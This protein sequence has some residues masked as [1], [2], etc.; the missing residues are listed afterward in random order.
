MSDSP[1]PGAGSQ[2]NAPFAMARA[3]R[4]QLDAGALRGAYE[5]Y[6]ELAEQAEAR[7]GTAE[8]SDYRENQ[9]DAGLT[10]VDALVEAE[11]LDEAFA[12]LETLAPLDH[13]HLADR[14]FNDCWTR[15]GSY[16]RRRL[17]AFEDVLAALA[18]YERLAALSEA[19]RRVPSARMLRVFAA[20]VMVARLQF[21]RHFD[22]A[23]AVADKLAEFVADNP[24]EH[25]D[26]VSD[27]EV[28]ALVTC[29]ACASMSGTQSGQWAGAAR[30]YRALRQLDLDYPDRDDVK[31]NCVAAGGNLCVHYGRDGLALECGQLLGEL[32]RLWPQWGGIERVQRNYDQMAEKFD[33]LLA[34]N[35]DPTYW[36]QVFKDALVA[37][38]EE[39]DEQMRVDGAMWL[40][41]LLCRAVEASGD[42]RLGWSLYEAISGMVTGPTHETD[43]AMLQAAGHFLLVGLIRMAD[44]LHGRPTAR[45]RFEEACSLP[46]FRDSP[47]REHL[48]EMLYAER[49]KPRWPWQRG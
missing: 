43:N 18:L 2:G 44:R 4:A 1:M 17:Q 47:A 16:V 36:E 26:P 19:F 30:Y 45:A 10:L 7:A 20:E 24:F 35:P 22:D 15:F 38:L 37:S 34:W 3:V 25:A 39:P 21:D 46:G 27:H 14:R 8:E 13:L 32:A 23:L 42:E 9:A 31:P 29:Y 48:E 49:K 11:R 12:A 33:V 28:G 5:A 41:G 40:S 6:M